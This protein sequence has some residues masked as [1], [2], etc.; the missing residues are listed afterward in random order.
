[1]SYA[2]RTLGPAE[3]KWP[4]VEKECLAVVHW[5]SKFRHYLLDKHFTVQTDH[6]ALGFL[7]HSAESP[8]LRVQ[9]W[10]IKLSPYNFT[11]VVRRGKQNA[12][13]DSMTR[14]P[15]APEVFIVARAQTGDQKPKIMNDDWEM[16]FEVSAKRKKKGKEKE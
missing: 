7:N 3:I 8:N 16:T 14:G 6:Q 13:A 9:R 10:A 1:V 5:I 15:I 4:T 12:N 2:S 11:V